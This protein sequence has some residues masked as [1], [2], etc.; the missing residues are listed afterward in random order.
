MN[1]PCVFQE[2]HCFEEYRYG[3]PD[4]LCKYTSEGVALHYHCRRPRC[5]FATDNDEQLQAH[6]THFHDNVT[7]ME[8][9][10]FFDTSVDCRLETCVK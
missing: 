6:S 1:C 8:G 3:C 2:Q 9:F 10:L 5:F 7:I 4:N